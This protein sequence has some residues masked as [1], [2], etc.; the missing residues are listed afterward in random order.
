MRALG[1]IAKCF[2]PSE[3]R[4]WT[5]NPRVASH[6]DIVSAYVASKH[7]SIALLTS[8]AADSKKGALC[9]M[10]GKKGGLPM[11]HYL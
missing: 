9:N 3:L 4:P 7:F 5:D 10:S 1:T 2:T 8:K 11:R 6:L